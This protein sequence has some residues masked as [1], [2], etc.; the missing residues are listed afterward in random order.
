MVSTYDT[1]YMRQPTRVQCF[2]RHPPH[3]IHRHWLT[4]GRSSAGV[5]PH[6]IHLGTE[7]SL[8]SRQ[9]ESWSKRK[10]HTHFSLTLQEH[11]AQHP[12][13]LTSSLSHPDS[14]KT[15]FLVSFQSKSFGKTNKAQGR[16]SEIMFESFRR[17]GLSQKPGLNSDDLS[18]PKQNLHAHIY[19]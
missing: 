3:V 17:K 4:H 10:I 2:F 18:R 14:V 16:I 5:K 12:R 9:A 6:G 1:W 19:M 7:W 15:T 13:G 11:T 8:I